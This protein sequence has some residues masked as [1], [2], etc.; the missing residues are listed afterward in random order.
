M[1]IEIRE[2]ALQVQAFPILYRQQPQSE[3]LQSVY[4][5]FPP[6]SGLSALPDNFLWLFAA[7]WLILILTVF[8]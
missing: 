2:K 5:I 6:A 4:R 3:L 7:V 8:S 1:S